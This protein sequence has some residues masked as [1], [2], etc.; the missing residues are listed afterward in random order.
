[1]P[2]PAARIRLRGT[3]QKKGQKQ[4]GKNKI[5]LQQHVFSLANIR[6]V[7]LR[8]D[9]VGFSAYLPIAECLSLKL[10]ESSSLR[11]FSFPAIVGFSRAGAPSAGTGWLF[12]SSRISSPI[13]T[14][15]MNN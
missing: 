11:S 10:P 1:M 12:R 5:I 13:Y 14:Q 15:E 2:V 3:D 7:N 8:V 4:I 6:Y 9:S